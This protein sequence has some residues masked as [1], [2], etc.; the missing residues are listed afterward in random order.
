M[1]SSPTFYMSSAD[2]TGEWA[3]SRPCCIERRVRGPY[4]DQ[5]A[6]LRIDPPALPKDRAKVLTHVWVSPRHEGDT[7]FPT[8][9][10][11][12]AVYVYTPL[13]DDV[14]GRDEITADDVRI[15]AWCELYS[16]KEAAERVA[17]AS[18]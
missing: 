17:A 4:H 18:T 16:Q 7:L 8:S 5:Y 6:L 15:E 3:R 12:L 9:A 13:R 2:L 10:D 11:P 14:F 1:A